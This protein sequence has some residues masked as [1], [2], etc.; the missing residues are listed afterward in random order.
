M[1]VRLDLALITEVAGRAV[2]GEVVSLMGGGGEGIRSLGCL[3]I[4]LRSQV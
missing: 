1:L 4:L 2:T 3:K